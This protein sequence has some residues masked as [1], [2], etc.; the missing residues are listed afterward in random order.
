MVMNTPVSSRKVSLPNAYDIPDRLLH[1]AEPNFEIMP[2]TTAI[3]RAP[4]DMYLDSE[5]K[6]PVAAKHA[7]HSTAF[8]HNIH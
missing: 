7:G 4:L 5:Y 3:D 6:S 1:T 2:P 8:A